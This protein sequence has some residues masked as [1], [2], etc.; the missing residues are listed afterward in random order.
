MALERRY[1]IGNLNRNIII[2]KNKLARGNECNLNFIS[3]F[4][5]CLQDSMAEDLSENGERPMG[6]GL[7][8][9]NI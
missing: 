9:C 1:D 5:L 6:L 7:I 8:L 2:D 3:L 4:I